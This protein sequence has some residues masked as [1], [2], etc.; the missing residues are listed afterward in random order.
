MVNRVAF[1]SNSNYFALK[2]S[3]QISDARVTAMKD[4]DKRRATHM[5]IWDK[6]QDFFRTEKKQDALN[7]LYE[8]IHG[9]CSEGERDS[10][11]GDYKK[12]FLIC[13]EV[14]NRLELYAGDGCK[15]LFKRDV[16][17]EGVMRLSIDDH[18]VSTWNLKDMLGVGDS[19]DNEEGFHDCL[20]DYF[21]DRYSDLKDV[22]KGFD[23]GGKEGGKVDFNTRLNLLHVFKEAAGAMNANR[24]STVINE[25]NDILWKVNGETLVRL[26]MGE[27][28]DVSDEKKLQPM[29]KMELDLFESMLV[30]VGNYKIKNN[31]DLAEVRNEIAKDNKI[32]DEMYSVY[33][34]L[35]ERDREPRDWRFGVKEGDEN[36]LVDREK[37]RE[38]RYNENIKEVN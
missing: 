27:F 7:A 36:I 1:N 24:F 3:R 8:A 32:I 29:N 4:G 38:F 5:G 37:G 16:D 20:I 35:G 22:Y 15:H 10:N 19:Q 12:S 28:L 25:N 21:K 2:P 30:F 26:S 9:S 18:E 14:F 34:N 11:A 33:R 23:S 6:I 31:D 17:N 13:V